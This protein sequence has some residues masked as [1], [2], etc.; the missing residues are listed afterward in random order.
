M[1]KFFTFFVII[2]FFTVSNEF[3]QITLTASDYANFYTVGNSYTTYFD[4]ATSSVDIGQPGGGNT[5]DFSNLHSLMTTVADMVSPSSTPYGSNYP[6]ANYAVYVKDDAGDDYG[7][8]SYYHL[9]DNFESCG[10][11]SKLEILSGI[12]TETESH[13]TPFEITTKLPLTAGVS[14][15]QSYEADVTST[16]SSLPPIAETDDVTVTRT[17]DAWGTLVIPGKAEPIEALRIRLDERRVMHTAAGDNYIRWIA[18]EFVTKIFTTVSVTLADTTSPDNGVVDIVG[19]GWGV[20]S[21]TAVNDDNPV[22]EN[23]R[24]DQNYPNPFNP[25]TTISFTLPTAEFVT[26]NV[27]NSIGQK[28]ATLVENEI[29][30]GTHQVQFNAANL[31]SGTYFYQLRAG[32]FIQT[33]KCLLIK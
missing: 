3:A 7:S 11:Y 20:S 16:T 10:N 8:Y 26:L 22:S 2:T 29:S 19:G 13:F 28:V 14:W 18:Y 6:N 24:L 17:V 5:W 33:K 25:T 30:A 4:Y 12:I 1:K 31:P 15:T 23:F 27:Y 32:G 9:G 21:V